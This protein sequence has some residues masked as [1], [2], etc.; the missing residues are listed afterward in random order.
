MNF[1]NFQIHT[2]FAISALSSLLL[3]PF[4]WFLVAKKRRKNK[5]SPFTEKMFRLP[6]HSLR[7]QKEALLE[8]VTFSFF[9]FILGVVFCAIGL[10]Y[11]EGLSTVMFN[12][13]GLAGVIMSLTSLTKTF[14]EVHKVNLG[15][16]GEE[17][18]GQE[19]NLLMLY[20][21]YV[22][23]DIPY[24]YGN[25]DHIVVGNNTVFAIETKAVSKP[26]T[27]GSESGREAKVKFDDK[28]L[29]FPHYSTAQPIDQASRHAQHVAEAIRKRCGFSFPVK[30][31]VALP[32]WYVEHS[33]STNSEVLVMNPLRGNF[34]RKWLGEVQDKKQRNEV[35]R[36]IASVA[37]SVPQSSKRTDPDWHKSYDFWSNPKHK[38]KI[39]G[40]Y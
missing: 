15:L 25:I 10:V 37:R 33:N 8:N 19:L 22:F 2:V 9:G 26:K 5:F 29:N 12:I 20:G 30:A 36:Y 1:D 13:A 40:E 27:E 6:G 32:G 28:A 34:L 7:I 11:K 23:H 31:V 39:L 3:I 35:I 16:E 38:A 18:T 4:I 14:N 21:A 17:Y 24:Q